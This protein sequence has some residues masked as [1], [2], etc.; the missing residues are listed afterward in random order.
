MQALGGLRSPAP[1]VH[2]HDAVK[3]RP[4]A[5]DDRLFC[6]LVLSAERMRSRA[7]SAYLETTRA[8]ADYEAVEPQ[9]WNALQ[10]RLTAIDQELMNALAAAV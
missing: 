6:N 7:W 8:A 5:R 2:Y 10:D 4:H 3:L 1:G 9:A